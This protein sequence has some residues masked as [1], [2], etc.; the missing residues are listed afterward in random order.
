LGQSTIFANGERHLHAL[1]CDT[2]FFLLPISKDYISSK[3]SLTVETVSKSE[4]KAKLER[5]AIQTAIAWG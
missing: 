1:R 2:H 3:G 5:S 4:A